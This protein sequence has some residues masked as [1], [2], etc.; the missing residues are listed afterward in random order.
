MLY[1]IS[2]KS[3][4]K[5]NKNDNTSGVATILSLVEN[6]TIDATQDNNEPKQDDHKIQE[7]V[8]IIKK[9]IKEGVISDE[10]QINEAEFYITKA[11]IKG[12]NM[13]YDW[14]TGNK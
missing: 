14:L 5:N 7:M 10:K 6:D 13:V 12:I 4:Y 3:C 1:F 2:E 9:A 8:N 11:D